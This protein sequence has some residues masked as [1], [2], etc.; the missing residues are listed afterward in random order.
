VVARCAS[1]VVFLVLAV[2]SARAQE[3]PPDAP[4]PEV[5]AELLNEEARIALERREFAAARDLL[6][7]SLEIHR[8]A[9]AAFNLARVLR[10]QGLP[11]EA[12]V[13]IEALRE[14]RYG[15][16]PPERREQL[17]AIERDARGDL[18]HLT[19]AIR[20]APS[21]ELRIDGEPS[22]TLRA[23]A[24]ATLVLDPGTHRVAATDPEGRSFER[25]VRLPRGAR[26][27]I[28]L[29]EAPVAPAVPERG[30]SILESPWL[31]IGAGALAVGAAIAIYFLATA[32]ADP[33]EDPFLGRAE[34]LRP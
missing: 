22:E 3:E 17:G 6:T 5:R 32:E 8:T 34:T 7:R 33:L 18:A 4:T 20:G 25:E 13:Y 21:M 28:E 12:L 27:R 29:G 26:M 9:R 31:W 2:P 24:P 19:I 14:G 16:L 10:E 30:G 1:V 11:T 23:S 15:A